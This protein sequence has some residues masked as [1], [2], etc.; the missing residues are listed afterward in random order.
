M[1]QTTTGMKKMVGI[2][3][4][5]RIL[6]VVVKFRFATTRLFRNHPF[7]ILCSEIVVKLVNEPQGSARFPRIVLIRIIEPFD[8]E[9]KISFSRYQSSMISDGFHKIFQVIASCDILRVC[10]SRIEDEFL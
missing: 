2:L 9:L 10:C 8:E 3:L 4:D 6:F 1:I 7:Q 5:I